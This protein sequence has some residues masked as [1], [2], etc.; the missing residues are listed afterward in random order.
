[1]STARERERGKKKGYRMW[2][3][4]VT[5]VTVKANWDRCLRSDDYGL[6]SQSH[7]CRFCSFIIHSLQRIQGLVTMPIPSQLQTIL[8]IN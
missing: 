5:H 8:I 4:T 2:M 3:S 1:M 6:D 7:L